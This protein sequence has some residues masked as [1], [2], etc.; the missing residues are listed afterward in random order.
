MN[1][2]IIGGG[3]SGVTLGYFLARLGAQVDIFE[4]SPTLGGLAAP[5][6]LDDGVAVDRFYHAVLPSDD[7]LHEICGELNLELRFRRTRNAFLVDGGIYS[8][9]SAAE[10]LRFQP[11]TLPE[12]M[13]LA[14]AVLRAQFVRDWRRLEDISVHDWLRRWSGPGVFE[15]LWRPMLAAKF[16]NAHEEIPAT[17]MW[18]RLVRMKSTRSGANQRESAGHIVGGY[19]ALLEAMARSIRA[20]GGR[21]HLKCPVQEIAIESGR[22]E[23]IRTARGLWTGGPIVSTMQAPV[24]RRLILNAP[25]RY[26]ESLDAVKYLGVVCPLVVL[27][28]PFSGYWVLNI[29]D[30][31]VPFTGIIETTTYID[32]A[33]V[34][35][36]HLVYLPKY[37]EPGSRWQDMTDEEVRA[38]AVATLKQV[39]PAFDPG[40]IWRVLV[41]RERYVEPLHVLHGADPVPTVITPVE[42]LFL[43][44][45]AQIYPAL[46]NG[47][48]VTRHA[49]TVADLLIDKLTPGETAMAF[50]ARRAV[51][52]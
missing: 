41:H 40:A 19:G 9:N 47:E 4:A 29:A 20:A 27:D 35:G 17:W 52:G 14:T 5:I 50:E 51:A 23:G 44:T 36:H 10:F 6:V 43:A 12:R 33:L 30:R 31:R 26:L 25:A 28:R 11:L 3:I 1:V 37:T 16:E 48:S 46:T 8:M 7:H 42:N 13:R 22:A 34:G 45:T 49:R 24:F 18:A 15:K 38:E 32:P 21:I 39:V 2:G